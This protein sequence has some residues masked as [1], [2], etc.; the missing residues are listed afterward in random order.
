MF[1]ERFLF[2]RKTKETN[3]GLNNT[4]HGCNSFEIPLNV[5][6]NTDATFVIVIEAVYVNY[7]HISRCGLIR[8]KTLPELFLFMVD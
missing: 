4:F 6:N 8:T 3:T 1:R 5:S 2:S 7:V